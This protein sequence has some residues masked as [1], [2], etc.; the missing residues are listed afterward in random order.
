[1]ADRREGQVSFQGPDLRTGATA[2]EATIGPLRIAAAPMVA[3]TL[4]LLAVAPRYGPHWDELY[5][6]MLPPRWW[7]VDQPPLTVWLS[8]LAARISD[9]IWVQRL[10]AIAAA[11]AGALVAGMYPRVLGA[12]PGPQ[13]LAAWAHAFT[14][15]PLIMGHV[16][17]TAAID[18]LAWEVVILLVL[19][20]ST[21][22]RRSLVWAGAVAGAACWNKLLIIVLVAAIIAALLLTDRWMLRTRSAAA[23]AC[24][25]GLL[26]AP[27]VVAQL[28]SGLPMMQVSAGLV[29]Q[30][31][32]L[33]RLVL[34][35]AIALF[36]GPPLLRVW[37]TGLVD[38]WR[39]PGRAG[40]FLL[41]ALALLVVWTLV[42]PSQPHYPVG[43]VLPALSMGWASP[44]LSE[45]WSRGRTRAVV[46][47]NAAVASLLS[48]PLLPA[49]E[50]WLSTLSTVNPTIRD[51]V[52]WPDYAQQIAGTRQDGE[53]VVVDTYALAG[54]VHRYGSASDRAA[55]HSGHNALWDLGP[56]RWDRVLLVG[57][58]AVAQRSAF[59]SCT[60]AGMLRTR[61][62]VHP[63]LVDVPMLRCSGPVDDWQTLWPRFRRLS[64]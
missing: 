11:A 62:V 43:A 45:R 50:P 49:S 57:E 37:V 38:P 14:V 39:L 54:A 24:L 28:A 15:Y 63:R 59:R 30:Q 51:Q 18:L 10:P 21:G 9:G 60:P 61:P 13:R 34:L 44:R 36:A 17:T 19:R 64:G 46:A 16:L 47:A 48:L 55:L 2:S 42:F 3:V 31:G 25:F 12:G 32:T 56:P 1:M 35:P 6:G 53:D 5:F 41:P 52:G 4:L 29:A 26:A 22:H 27:Q 7:Y 40:R 23:G 20:A 58:H 8:W 33:V